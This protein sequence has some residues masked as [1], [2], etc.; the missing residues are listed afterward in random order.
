MKQRSILLLLVGVILPVVVLSV[1]GISFFAENQIKQL[2]GRLATEAAQDLSNASLIAIEGPMVAGRDQETQE[3]FKRL[4]AH[5]SVTVRIVSARFPNLPLVTYSS[6]PGE[7]H[8]VI[9][10]RRKLNQLEASPEVLAA[11]DLLRSGGQSESVVSGELAVTVLKTIPNARECLHCHSNV[12]VGRPLGVVSVRQD[13][14][15]FIGEAEKTAGFLLLF[16]ASAEVVTVLLISLLLWLLTLRPLTR[17]LGFVGRVGDED[18]RD[19]QA[20]K[21]DSFIGREIRGLARGLNQMLSALDKKDQFVQETIGGAVDRLMNI[22]SQ[23]MDAFTQ[24]RQGVSNQSQAAD[25]IG[26]AMADISQ[27][28]SS[29]SAQVGQSADAAKRISQSIAGGLQVTDRMLEAM[30]QTH[31]AAQ[32]SRQSTAE[33]AD[34]TD[35][36]GK[37]VVTIDSIAFQTKLLAL[38]AAIE[39]AR[40]GQHGKGFAVVAQEVQNLA[41]QTGRAAQEIQIITETAMNR[42]HRSVEQ[43]GQITKNVELTSK[44]AGDVAGLIN[45]LSGFI[46]EITNSVDQINE[47]AARQAAATEQTHATSERMT[48]T[49]RQTDI[50]VKYMAE[51]VEALNEITSKLADLTGHLVD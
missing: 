45:E 23:L 47:S 26:T 12:D 20:L 28:A 16:I 46:Q 31:S 44:L 27:A 50:T 2:A 5:D 40:A 38:N 33:V 1:A 4:A 15:A 30:N 43:E 10:Q 6:K 18:A 37:I 51:I 8:L 25:H 49:N 35:E 11:M 14:G 22:I 9:D 29:V 19:L 42:I 13:V 39:A 32:M 21:V 48:E 17:I 36:I 7:A 3:V 41:N 24:I 34:M